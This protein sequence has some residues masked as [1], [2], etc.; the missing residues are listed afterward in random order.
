MPIA[1]STMA[2][3]V[4]VRTIAR[5]AA[6]W[7][8]R[9]VPVGGGI[10]L[11]TQQ[12]GPCIYLLCASSRTFCSCLTSSRVSDTENDERHLAIP[13]YTLLSSPYVAALNV[14]IIPSTPS[15]QTRT[16]Q[17]TVHH[18]TQFPCAPSARNSAASRSAGLEH[19]RSRVLPR[20][21]L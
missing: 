15:P 16:R 9:T 13:K 11:S 20:F 6:I 17:R 5:T 21:C 3:A 19:P 8:R 2:M 7:R 18:P 1:I 10:D 4:S 12:H 14:A